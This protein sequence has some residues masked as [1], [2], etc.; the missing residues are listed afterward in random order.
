MY[1]FNA[2]YLLTVYA[3]D[4][5]G[6]F[7]HNV[8]DVALVHVQRI[9]NAVPYLD[10]P[11]EDFWA[12]TLA[13]NTET[14]VTFYATVL[15]GNGD[16]CDVNF[17]FGDGSYEVKRQPT[18][19][20]TVSVTHMYVTAGAYLA[21]LDA[22]DGQDSMSPTPDP[23]IIDVAQAEYTLSLVTGWNFVTVPRVGWGYMASTLGLN[24]NDI[25][26]GWNPSSQTYDKTYVVN[27]SLPFKDFPIAQSTGYWIYTNGPRILHLYGALPTEEQFR[28]LTVPGP[29]SWAIVG[30]NTVRADMKASDIVANYTSVSGGVVSQGVSYNTVTGQY[31][32]YN[33]LL[34]FT[35][36]FLASGQAYWIM[37][38]ATGTLS[39]T[40]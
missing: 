1:S 26:A 34:P 20:S 40:T 15:D 38:N 14:T 33:P 29:G 2:D 13:P 10:V 19:N 23:L 31:K 22:S 27:V 6:L 18:A 8:S 24:T 28:E 25:V 35:N 16:I 37:V 21:Y 11:S 36:F 5:T 12:S 9:G 3:D 4:K 30:F 17:T 32:T 7:E 39:Y